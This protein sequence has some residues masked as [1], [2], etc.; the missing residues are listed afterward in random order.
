MANDKHFKKFKKTMEKR[1]DAVGYSGDQGIKSTNP[2]QRDDARTFAFNYALENIV[3]SDEERVELQARRNLLGDDTFDKYLLTAIESETLRANDQLFDRDNR[4]KVL[5]EAPLEKIAK[6]YLE[7]TP[8]LIEGNDSHNKVA[9]RHAEYLNLTNIVAAHEAEKMSDSEI[10]G[11]AVEYYDSQ[12]KPSK[13]IQDRQANKVKARVRDAFVQTL[14][15]NPAIARAYLA[16]QATRAKKDVEKA[17]PTRVDKK[18]YV[19]R[20]IEARAK[21]LVEKQEA[22]E[23]EY[24]GTTDHDR[25]DDIEDELDNIY[26]GKT[27]LSSEFYSIATGKQ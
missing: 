11:R 22:L 8:A 3:Q 17:L 14:T 25:R 9:K 12:N 1:S 27:Q 7:M 21:A 19:T 6:N 20:T 4:E 5:S 2:G 18:A 15:V 26:N 16:G 23:T 24:E 13:R 10:F